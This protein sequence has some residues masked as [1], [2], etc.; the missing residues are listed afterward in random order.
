MTSLG[1]VCDAPSPEYLLTSGGEQPLCQ[2]CRSPLRPTQGK[3]CSTRCRQTA[4]RF[5]RIAAVE[6]LGDSPKRLVYADP[7]F[8]GLSGYYRGHPDYGGEVDHR[9]L[10]EQ[11][12][13]Y[14]GWA[15][16]TSADAL[17]MVL[18]L[19]P[20]GVEYRVC[21]W[22]K[23]HPPSR[24]RG[25]SNVWEPLIVSPAR[26]RFPGVPDALRAAVAR[27]GDS[28]LI[29]RKPLAFVSWLFALLGALP[30]DSFV[31]KFPGSGIVGRCWEEFCRKAE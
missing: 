13:T 16:S 3:W 9:H 7:P 1:A 15:L 17:P 23:V 31:D 30:C 12:V 14:D 18:S 8:P 25:P 27:G 11:L 10:C 26:R 4:W 6:G 5:R 22:L 19:I 28:D 2:W 29:G 20:R 21:P 24:A